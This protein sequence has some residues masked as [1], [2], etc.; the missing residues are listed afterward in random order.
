MYAAT[1]GLVAFTDLTV[2]PTVFQAAYI[3]GFL[4]LLGLYPRVADQCPWLARVG[5]AAAALGVIAFTVFAASNLVELAG[6]ASG[7]IPAGSVFT[8]MGLASFVVGYLTVGAAV[9]RSGA[10]SRTVGILLLIPGV[11]IVLMFASIVAG[12]TSPESV[13]VV[14][15]G[16][17]MTHLAIGSTLRAETR[18]A[19]RDDAEAAPDATVRG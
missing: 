12:V 17:A 19:E 4:G 8:A 13:F 3:A 7:E 1:N 18:S 14:S 15:A 10:Y 16:Q 6:I 5:A 9:L 2:E 11:I